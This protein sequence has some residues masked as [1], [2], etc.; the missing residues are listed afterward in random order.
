MLTLRL[1]I[2]NHLLPF[3]T[4]GIF[5]QSDNQVPSLLMMDL[6]LLKILR[7]FMVKWEHLGIILPKV[8]ISMKF[9]EEFLVWQEEKLLEFS[10]SVLH[11]K[12]KL[13]MLILQSTWV[14]MFSMKLIKLMYADKLL[15]I[16][17]ER[18]LKYYGHLLPLMKW[19]WWCMVMHPFGKCMKTLGIQFQV[20]C[21][22]EFILITIWEC[23][24]PGLSMKWIPEFITLWLRIRCT[25]Q[26]M[27]DH[28]PLSKIQMLTATCGNHKRI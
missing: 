18:K 1:S 14:L 25:F 19:Q 3:T 20:S 21:P 11:L 22:S 4:W 9:W 8:Q 6:G 5:I 26:K 15:L 2:L 27:S 10:N 16:Q 24:T 28:I 17:R 23:P 12:K 7:N 13:I